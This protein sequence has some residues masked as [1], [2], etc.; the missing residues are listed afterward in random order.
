V[1]ADA[2]LIKPLRAILP[3]RVT[4]AAAGKILRG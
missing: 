4:E 1:G 3:V 2:M